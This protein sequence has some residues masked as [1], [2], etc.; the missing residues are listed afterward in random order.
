[1]FEQ[2]LVQALA[3]R[4]RPWNQVHVGDRGAQDERHAATLVQ[5]LLP[6]EL[7]RRHRRAPATT[8]QGAVLDVQADAHGSRTQRAT[9]KQ[10]PSGVH[11]HDSM[12]TW[13][14]GHLMSEQVACGTGSDGC[15]LAG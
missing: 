6:D 12:Q 5:E 8:Q 10:S 3:V 2:P 11:C 7:S 15:A 1:M 14:G 4:S 13:P 9:W